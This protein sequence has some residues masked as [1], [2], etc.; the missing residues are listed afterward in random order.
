[1][2]TTE[3]N[4]FL[5]SLGVQYTDEG[6]EHFLFI[7]KKIADKFYD[8]EIIPS[9]FVKAVYE[10]DWERA[11]CIAD[12]RNKEGFEI[13]LF[14]KLV[15]YIKSTPLYISNKREDKLNIIYERIL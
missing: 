13:N 10:E 12:T 5:D 7:C 2:T 15:N 3:I 4:K 6:R 8:P 11:K 1:V 9:S 14:Q